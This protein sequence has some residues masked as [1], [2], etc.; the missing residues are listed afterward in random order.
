M[1]RTAKGL[2]RAKCY[3]VPFVVRPDEKHKEFAV[4]FRAFAV[5][6]WHATKPLFPVV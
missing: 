2:Y 5:R 6:P 4:H 3:C 1:R